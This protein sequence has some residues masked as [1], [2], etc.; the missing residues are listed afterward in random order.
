MTTAVS[1]PL[2]SRLP[3][4]EQT[5]LNG[6]Q[7]LGVGGFFLALLI[8]FSFRAQNFAQT[9]NL[10]NILS[11]VAV[12]GV[13]ALGQAYVLISGGFD[14]SV[15]GTVP[16]G[17]IIY[18]TACNDG[19]GMYAAAGLAI[20]AGLGVGLAN[21]LI[22]TQIK[23]N[24]LITTL[25]TLSII[26]GLAFVVSNGITITLNNPNLAPLGNNF[27]GVQIT[28]WLFFA[29]SIVMFLILRYTVFGRMLYAMGG[30]RE[31]ARLAGLRVDV[32]TTGVYMIS[33][34]LSSFAGVMLA[35]QLLAG[36]PTVA[37]SANL[38]SITA[39]IVGG[40]SLTGGTGG[41]PGTVLGV[42][43]LGTVANGMTLMQV[44][45]FY[46]Q[47]ATGAILL[48]AVGLGWVRG[49]VQDAVWKRSRYEEVVQSES[50]G[51]ETADEA[52]QDALNQREVGR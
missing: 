10:L 15:S 43:V 4:V 25:A 8:F 12:V 6:S 37:S 44:P 42:L 24:P 47:I 19:Y 17:G 29:F 5:I 41:I 45:T 23:I 50:S 3:S 33:G 11:N 20:A 7:L 32:V 52:S 39:V 51:G 18:V 46:Q 48:L 14:L 31:A 35:N 40:A 30:N 22:I 36:A 9:S 28:I 27:L 21:G 49:H 13:V 2:R 34:G 16:L 26:G 38:Q 1:R